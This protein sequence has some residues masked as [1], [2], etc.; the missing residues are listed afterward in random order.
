M[1]WTVYWFQS[2]ACFIFASIAIFSGISGAALMLPWFVMGFALLGVPEIS[3]QQAIAASLFLESAAFSIGL[4][5]YWKRNLIHWPTV[6]KLVT[7]ALPASVA[8]ALLAHQAPEIWLRLVY[9]FLMMGAAWLLFTRLRETSRQKASAVNEHSIASDEVQL[10]GANVQRVISGGGAFMTGLISTGIG[11]VTQPLLIV[12]SH[13][14]VPIAAATSIV[15]VAVADLGAIVTHFSQFL[16]TDGITSIPWNLIVWGVPGMAGG[17][18]LG[19]WLQGRVNAYAAQKFF[20]ALF[21]LLALT[22]LLYTF[23]QAGK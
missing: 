5:R 10:H 16:L 18:A 7:L 20:V 14:P 12:R 21:V 2:I 6:K 17:A 11:E 15:L 1:D 9:S 19:S 3:M 8:G 13:F 23:T 4:Y 22:F